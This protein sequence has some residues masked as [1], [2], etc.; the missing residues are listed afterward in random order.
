MG[1]DKITITVKS[2]NNIILTK[3]INITVTGNDTGLNIS[4]NPI[5][6]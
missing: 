4:S 5:I 2:G 1:S 3:E 6:R